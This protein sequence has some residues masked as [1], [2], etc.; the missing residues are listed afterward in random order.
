MREGGVWWP[1]SLAWEVVQATARGRIGGATLGA[2]FPRLIG[3]CALRP[4]GLHR[5]LYGTQI[6]GRYSS[7]GGEKRS[8]FG[9]LRSLLGAADEHLRRLPISTGHTGWHCCTTSAHWMAE[10]KHACRQFPKVWIPWLRSLAG[11]MTRSYLLIA[12]S[13]AS[14][15][16]RMCAF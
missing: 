16:L 5:T 3:P 7:E 15:L 6:R 11:C 10:P 9:R 12:P 4:R 1:G 2:F 8:L 14:V 13:D